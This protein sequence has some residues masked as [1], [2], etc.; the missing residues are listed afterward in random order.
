LG[1]LVG[2]SAEVGKNNVTMAWKKEQQ[3]E[4]VKDYFEKMKSNATIEYI[5]R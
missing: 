2:E 1:R 3:G 5:R 4:A